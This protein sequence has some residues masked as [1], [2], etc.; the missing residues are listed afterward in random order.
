MNGDN[1]TQT[2]RTVLYTAGVT[3]G[4]AILGS[5]VSVPSA[6]QEAQTESSTPTPVSETE[7][8]GPTG[9]SSSPWSR[10]Y[11]ERTA[12]TTYAMV[13][14]DEGSLVVAGR[15]ESDQH[16][17]DAWLFK[18]ATTTGELEWSRTYEGSDEADP[19]P[20]D[21]AE[22][23]VQTQDGGFA[24]GGTTRHE[25]GANMPLLVK[26]DA[27]G[28][29]T[30][31][32][33]YETDDATHS[34][35]LLQT[36][37]G[38]YLLLGSGVAIRVDSDGTELWRTQLTPDTAGF[39]YARGVVEAHDDGYIVAG[40]VSS[41]LDANDIY[42]VKIGESGEIVWSRRFDFSVDDWANDI[43]RTETGYALAGQTCEGGPEE[44]NA[45]LAHLTTSGEWEWHRTYG[46]V[47]NDE[48][49]A[50]TPTDDGGFFLGGSDESPADGSSYWMVKT[51]AT[52]EI[53]WSRR[54]N[55][56]LFD[57][58]QAPNGDYVSTGFSS[59]PPSDGIIVNL[60]QPE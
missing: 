45:V 46:G 40:S 56:Y 27:D 15:T 26:T 51:T 28:R 50:L 30:M 44:R 53:E 29:P 49:L 59:L 14:T 11:N 22:A 38:G 32:Q 20:Y 57:V 23:V 21:S 60:G 31:M 52:G 47:Q 5:A 12:D 39:V 37:D 34:Q 10:A 6:G 25:G 9:T 33:A 3:L 48:F 7:T 58:A 13:A 8:T 41:N 55:S 4:T 19:W 42:V 1:K 35:D 54:R 16:G 17:N 36:A 2:R 24:V 18:V 43:V